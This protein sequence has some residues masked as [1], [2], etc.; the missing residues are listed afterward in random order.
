MST[1]LIEVT[2]RCVVDAR[3]P[4]DLACALDMLRSQERETYPSINAGVSSRSGSFQIRCLGVSGV[5]DG[6]SLWRATANYPQT[7]GSEA[8]VSGPACE[9]IALRAEVERLTRERDEARSITVDHR[10]RLEE[11]RTLRLAAESRE[12]EA[13]A[14]LREVEWE[15]SH[16]GRACCPSCGGLPPLPA[17]MA[18]EFTLKDDVIGHYPDCRLDRAALDPSPGGEP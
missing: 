10:V 9:V 1:H 18:R 4:S 7:A 8:S 11:E 5:A 2:L 15:G 6:A 14:E 13:R 3:K 12:A 17:G 16:M